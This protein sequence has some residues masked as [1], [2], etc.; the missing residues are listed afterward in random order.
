M[1]FKVGDR[2][3]IRENLNEYGYFDVVPD[4]LKYRGKESVILNVNESVVFTSYDLEGIPHTWYPDSLEPVGDTVTMCSDGNEVTSFSVNSIEEV[5][6]RTRGFKIVSDEFRKHPDVNIQLPKRGTKKSAGYDI[7]TPVDIIIPPNGISDAIQTDIKA[8]M[9]EDEVLEI[10]PR[11][12]IGFKKGLMLINT[13]G[14]I[15]SDFYSNPDNDGN[16]GFKF[17]NLTDET[18]EIKAGERI[19]QGIFRKYLTTE[20]DF[21][22]TERVGGIGSTN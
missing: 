16:I 15:D 11:S 18:V 4:M 5:P 3:R 12:S 19:L 9:L 6:I 2:V 14:I 17:K 22:E 21:C 13:V 7:C 10:V 8:Y 1:K 20:D